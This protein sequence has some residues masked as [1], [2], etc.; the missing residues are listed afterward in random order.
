MALGAWFR[1]MQQ[2]Y[3]LLLPRSNKQTKK[4]PFGIRDLMHVT[5]SSRTLDLATGKHLFQLPN[6]NVKKYLIV[7]DLLPSSTRKMILE[8]V[9]QLCK[10]ALCTQEV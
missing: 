7:Y 2:K 10:H 8:G 9:D 6:F 3:E 4:P 5:A 1:V